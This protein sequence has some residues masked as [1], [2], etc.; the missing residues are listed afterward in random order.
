MVSVAEAIRLP[1]EV[2]DGNTVDG[3]CSFE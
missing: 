2:R 1:A 3:N